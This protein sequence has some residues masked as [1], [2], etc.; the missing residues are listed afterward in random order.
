MRVLNFDSHTNDTQFA[1][2]CIYL[3]QNPVVA[4]NPDAK[5]SGPPFNLVIAPRPRVFSQIQVCFEGLDQDVIRKVQSLLPGGGL[6]GNLHL[7]GTHQGA[8]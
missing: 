8:S 1:F 7:Q 5:D 3:I 6:D 2:A 4:I